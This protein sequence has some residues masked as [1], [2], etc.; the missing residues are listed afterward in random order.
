MRSA[1]FEQL[2]AV[3]GP[4]RAAAVVAVLGGCR[5]N[6]NKKQDFTYLA[7]CKKKPYYDRLKPK[8]AAIL[9]GCSMRYFKKLRSLSN[10]IQREQGI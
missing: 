4:T 2:V 5:I 7:Y 8:I 3:I 1:K 6:I 10:K 9:L